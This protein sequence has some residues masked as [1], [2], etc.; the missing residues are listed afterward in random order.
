[1]TYQY[2]VCKF[3]WH[4]T[5]AIHQH[6]NMMGEAEWKLVSMIKNENHVV[7]V[8]EREYPAL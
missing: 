1:M 3:I 2:D 4:D 6:L 5:D 8:M 7:I